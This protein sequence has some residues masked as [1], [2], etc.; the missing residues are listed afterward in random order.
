MADQQVWHHR[1]NYLVGRQRLAP[2]EA[3]PWHRDPF[4]SR[5]WFLSGDLPHIEFCDGE[6]T[7]P[8][9]MF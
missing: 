2:G 6:E 8:W 3:T 4:R 7:I 1:E 5:P 9:Q